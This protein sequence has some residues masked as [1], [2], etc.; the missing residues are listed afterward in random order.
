M[1]RVLLVDDDLEL[2]AMLKEYLAQEGFEGLPPWLMARR[3][4]PSAVGQIR[5]CR[6]RRD[7]AAPQRRRCLCAA[8]SESRMPVLMLTARGDD[9][10]RIV[11]LEP[12]RRR[13]C[14]QALQ[15]PRTGGPP[16][17]HPATHGKPGV[18]LRRR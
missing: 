18:R 10:D 7:D 17:R 15:P 2:S 13:L 11:G 1:T 6:A 3:A 4:L 16:A 14:A 12:G 8:S 5:D 9:V